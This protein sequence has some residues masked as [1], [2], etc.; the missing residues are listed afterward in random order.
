[1]TLCQG[2][3]K[4]GDAEAAAALAAAAAAAVE[5]NVRSRAGPFPC[6]PARFPCVSIAHGQHNCRAQSSTHHVAAH[7]PL[8]PCHVPCSQ[9]AAANGDGA[10]AAAPAP[11]DEAEDSPELHPLKEALQRARLRLEEASGIRWVGVDCASA[12]RL[13]NPPGSLDSA[14]AGRRP[15]C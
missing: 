8:P 14:P 1:M 5:A 15:R 7:A 12:C 3:G 9:G 11:E 4:E 13:P 2:T 10:P 6:L